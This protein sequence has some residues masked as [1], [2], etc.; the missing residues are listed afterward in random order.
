MIVFSDVPGA[1]A[2]AQL[3]SWAVDLAAVWHVFFGRL[4]ASVSDL[5]TLRMRRISLCSFGNV[6]KISVFTLKDQSGRS[7]SF[8][9]RWTGPPS[10][11]LQTIGRAS[12][13]VHIQ[14]VLM[15]RG[16]A[17]DPE[18]SLM[19]S[20]HWITRPYTRWRTCSSYTRAPGRDVSLLA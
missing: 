8:D 7:S 4:G 14:E 17:D 10:D 16:P 15:L 13:P 12:R 20:L 3:G 9:L 19:R 18:C 6:Q 1:P 5:Y 11:F 2:G